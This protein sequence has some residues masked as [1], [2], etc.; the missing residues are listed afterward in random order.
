MYYD[1]I[2]DFI[3]KLNSIYSSMVF[4]SRQK[5]TWLNSISQWRH[6][7]VRVTTSPATR[8]LLQHRIVKANKIAELRNTEPVRESTSEQGIGAYQCGKRFHA[9]ASLYIFMLIK[10]INSVAIHLIG[11]YEIIQHRYSRRPGKTKRVRCKAVR[12]FRY[13]LMN[14]RESHNDVIKWKHFPRYSRP[15]FGQFRSPV[16]SLHKGK[17]RRALKFSLIYAWIK[18]WDAGGLRRHRADYDVTVMSFL[19]QRKFPWW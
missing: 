11:D 8:L 2:P 15:L 3:T 17:W 12:S 18:G 9:I 4:H 13:D 6:M 1:V 19:G 10:V 5:R 7:S 16:N 14:S